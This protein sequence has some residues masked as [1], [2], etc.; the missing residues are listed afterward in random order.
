ML[1]FPDIFL[2]A[3]LIG[4]SLVCL[5]TS[6]YSIEHP[7]KNRFSVVTALEMLYKK[8]MATP[9]HT[10]TAPKVF[11]TPAKPPKKRPLPKVSSSASATNVPTQVIH[12]ND[13][14]ILWVSKGALAEVSKRVKENIAISNTPRPGSLMSQAAVSTWIQPEIHPTDTLEGVIRR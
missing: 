1:L 2:Q 6:C 7:L 8:I 13:A 10:I 9:Q 12:Q 4:L 5:T 3:I 11:P 14:P